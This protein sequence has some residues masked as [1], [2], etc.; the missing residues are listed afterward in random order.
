MQGCC[1][2]YAIMTAIPAAHGNYL[3]PCCCFSVSCC[4]RK[5]RNTLMYMLGLTKYRTEAGFQRFSFINWSIMQ[6][7]W[8]NHH[9][10]M[11][12]RS[13]KVARKSMLTS[14]L[15]FHLNQIQEAAFRNRNTT[16]QNINTNKKSQNKKLFNSYVKRKTQEVRIDRPTLHNVHAGQEEA[17]AGFQA[18]TGSS[19]VP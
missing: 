18:A 1:T 14:V 13:R 7:A 10:H 16:Q 4:I 9:N 8:I 11:L 2:Y 6:D 19:F 17:Y 3:A 15:Q 12:S 5:A